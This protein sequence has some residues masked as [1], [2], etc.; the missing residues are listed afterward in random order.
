V[1]VETVYETGRMSV[2]E[3]AD[4]DEAKSAIKAHHDRAVNGEPGGPVGAPAERIAAVYVY[5]KH[6]DDYNPDQTASADVVTS[7]VAA[8]VKKMKD[9]NGV[10]NVDQLA[11]AVRDISHPMQQGTDREDSFG[12]FYKMKESKKLNLDFLEA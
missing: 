11:M 9:E 8:L 3:Y 5:D 7:E 10:I 12:S 2:G 4:E 6:P 1:F